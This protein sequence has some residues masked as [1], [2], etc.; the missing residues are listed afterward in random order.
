MRRCQGNLSEPVPIL[1]VPSLRMIFIVKAIRDW[2]TNTI[3]N[4]SG[5]L[6]Q[7]NAMDVLGNEYEIDTSK[8]IL[9]VRNVRSKEHSHLPKRYTTSSRSPRE[10]AMRRA[11]SW[12]SVNP[13]TLELLPK[14]ATGGGGKISK[15]F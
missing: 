15:T 8:P 13:V 11:T 6:N 14:A 10:A 5:I 2:L 12:L 9:S 3:T 1:A 4:T 7:T